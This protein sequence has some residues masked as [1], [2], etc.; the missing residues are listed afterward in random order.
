MNEIEE[1]VSESLEL[2]DLLQDYHRRNMEE[3]RSAVTRGAAGIEASYFCD[4]EVL[5]SLA[6]EPS[7]R[8]S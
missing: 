5:L 8:S 1:P 2:R 3:I 4:Q 6:R 7:Q